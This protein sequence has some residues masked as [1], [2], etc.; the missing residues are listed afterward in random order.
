MGHL[1]RSTSTNFGGLDKQDEIF[2]R[3]NY[4]YTIDQ[5]PQAI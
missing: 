1:K 3:T 4:Y 5:D 2:L